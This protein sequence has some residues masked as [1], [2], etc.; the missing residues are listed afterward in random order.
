LPPGADPSRQPT[1]FDPTFD[2]TRPVAIDR[3]HATADLFPRL[4][5]RPHRT[6]IARCIDG[7]VIAFL[8]QVPHIVCSPPANVIGLHGL[9][10]LFSNELA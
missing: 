3:R 2:P 10:D 4:V 7:R 6:C 5:K 1:I 9:G 8:T